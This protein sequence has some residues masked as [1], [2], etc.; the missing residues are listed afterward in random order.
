MVERDPENRLLSHMSRFRMSAEIVRDNAL[1][2]SGLLNAKIGGQSAYPYQPS[3]IWEEISRGEIF[4]AQVYKESDGQDL[5]RRGMYWF[6]KRSAPPASLDIFN[7]PAREICR[8]APA[9]KPPMASSG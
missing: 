3:G 4:S 1:A 9:T 7:A 6:W 2:V 8:S 5:Y